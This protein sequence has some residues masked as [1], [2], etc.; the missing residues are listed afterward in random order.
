MAANL[1]NV[2]IDKNTIISENTVLTGGEEFPVIIEKNS[3]LVIYK[4]NFT[5]YTN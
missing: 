3:N 5:L 4:S 2:I 1:T